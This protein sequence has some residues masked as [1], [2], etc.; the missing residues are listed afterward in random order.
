MWHSGNKSDQEQ[1]GCRFDPW[2]RSVGL[3]SGIAMS[4]GLG[5]RGGS[6]LALLWLWHSLAAVDPIRSLA[7][8]HSYAAGAALK[9]WKPKKK[10][11]VQAQIS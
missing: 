3:G 7:W 1:G 6:D 8:E 4:C 2:P 11:K 9:R 5:H 10:K